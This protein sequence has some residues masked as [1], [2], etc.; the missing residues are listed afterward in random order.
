[1]TSMDYLRAAQP[2]V[3]ALFLVTVLAAM[4]LCGDPAVW[5]VLAVLVATALT[6]GGAATLNNVIERDLDRSMER[7]RRRPTASGRITPARATLAGLAGVAAGAAALWAV[8]GGLAAVF[9]LLGAFYYVVVYTLLLKPRTALS[10]V[11]GGVAGVFPALIGWA[12]TGAAWSGAILFLCVL[13][14]VWSPP[15]SWALTLALGEDYRASGI[16]TPPVR[17]GDDVTRRLIAGFV[18]ALTVVLA[19]PLGAGLFGAV[20]AAGV[21]VAVVLLWASTARLLGRP[22]TATAWALF[23]VTGPCLALVLAA[24]VADQLA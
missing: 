21:I 10:A 18:A 7:T 17:Y 6:V 2:R 15:H 13:I 14:P 4:L 9:A 19:A 16:P 8:A 24:A 22:S 3:V 12:A 5:R 11:P 1:M 23:K 20:Y